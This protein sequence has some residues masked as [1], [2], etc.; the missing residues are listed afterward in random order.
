MIVLEYR[1]N[2][3]ELGYA[4]KGKKARLEKLPQRVIIFRM[5]AT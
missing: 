5:L 3:E 4:S 2:W 1:K